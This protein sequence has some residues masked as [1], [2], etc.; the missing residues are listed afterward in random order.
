MLGNAP[1]SEL[2]ALLHRSQL[3]KASSRQVLFHRGS[4]GRAVVV[5]LRGF[6]K[7]SS[8]EAGG[9]EVVL[10]ICGP[11]SLF[12]ELAA[13]NGWPR[14]AD[15]TALS[16]CEVLSIPGEALRTTLVRSPEALF[17]LLGV[18]SRRLRHATELIRD[19]ATLPGPARLAKALVQL[20]A[21][22]GRPSGSSLYLDFDLFQRELA[23]LTG[24]TRETINK[25]LAA[26]RELGWIEQ[27]PRRIRLLAAEPLRTLVEEASGA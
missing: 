14:A 20:A 15:A 18:L 25:Q 19:S 8:V 9:K 11:G 5:V 4:S 26:W 21:E 24:L 16:A 10:E 13:L 2:E 17:A 27:S 22:F 12:G 7:L 1:D 6:V 23:G 3:V